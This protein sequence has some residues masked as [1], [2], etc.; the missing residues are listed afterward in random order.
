[1]LNPTASYRISV[2]GIVRDIMKGRNEQAKNRLDKWAEAYSMK[3]KVITPQEMF[4]DVLSEINKTN[5]ALPG[6]KSTLRGMQR[7]QGYGKEIWPGSEFS[8]KP[9]EEAIV[10]QLEVIERLKRAPLLL[11]ELLEPVDNEE[12]ED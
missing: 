6:A 11:L 3:G 9:I 12:L 4:S 10:G 7:W 1:M 2:G 8:G 5:G